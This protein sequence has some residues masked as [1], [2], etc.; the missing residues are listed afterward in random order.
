MSGSLAPYTITYTALD[1]SGDTSTDAE[2][3]GIDAGLPT[4]TRSAPAES[5]ATPP[6]PGVE[7]QSLALS[8]GPS[9]T[10]TGIAK[11]AVGPAPG[12][13]HAETSGVRSV[14]LEIRGVSVPLSPTVVIT[15]SQ[16]CGDTCPDTFDYSVPTD[17]PPG[18]WNLRVY[19]IDL[20]GNRGVS[21]P[22]VTF[23]VIP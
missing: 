15:V 6:V 19:P 4:V 5:I 1:F 13:S 21:A 7:R 17:L 11:D 20:A 12:F 8:P 22:Q 23:V 3:F 16:S 10:V 18:I 14:E 9:P 2:E